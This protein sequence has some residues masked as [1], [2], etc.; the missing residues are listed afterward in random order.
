M[1]NGLIVVP[2][3]NR[4]THLTC[5]L[6]YMAQVFPYI[7]IL[8]V[9][10]YDDEPW[11]KG[12]LFNAAYKELGHSYDYMILH[13]VDFIP[14]QS[15]DYSYCKVPTLLSTEC[16]QF[17]YGFCY[18][19]FFGGVVGVSN[20]HFNLVNGFSNKFKGWGGEDDHFYKSFLQKGITPVKRIGNR[21]ENF[22]HPRL[23][24]RPKVGKDWN[25]KDYQ[26]NLN[27]LRTPRDFNEGLSTANYILITGTK[28][29]N[30]THL[31]IKTNG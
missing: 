10:Q 14:D 11:N 15:V 30:Y 19:T 24:V 1:E 4:K 18:D 9:E 7:P 8:V 28:I 2:Y 29:D 5:F 20:E 6:S 26:N 25:N 23:D 22:I 21:F 3:R 16:S 31:K 13:D 27:L 17:N 12:L